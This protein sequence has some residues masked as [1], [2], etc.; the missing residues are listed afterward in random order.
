MT[1]QTAP[2]GERNKGPIA[3]AFADASKEDY[4]RV[5]KGVTGVVITSQKTGEKKVYS[6]AHIP[7]EVQHQLVMYA[8]ATKAKQHVNNHAD[9]DDNVIVLIDGVYKDLVE[10]KMYAKAA[11]GKGPGKKTDF[12]LYVDAMAAAIGFQAK[13]GHINP[14]TKIA[15]KP[16]TDEQK[17]N[18]RLK[19][20]AFSRAERTEY[21]KQLMTKSLFQKCY[22]EARSKRIQVSKDE[23]LDSLL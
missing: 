7:A 20:E 16:M 9:A 10:G 8:F 17:A 4:K 19:L 21:V 1:T 15:I 2:K 23:D 12:S 18:F 3:V 14:K 13:K 11:E 22:Q 6:L 5:P